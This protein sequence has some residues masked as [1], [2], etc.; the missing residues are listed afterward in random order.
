[1]NLSADPPVERVDPSSVLPSF[2]SE[3]NHF[4]PKG[5]GGRDTSKFFRQLNHLILW[6][7][8]KIPS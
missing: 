8:E 1:M 5:C 6:A 4:M 7:L 3:N 2:R